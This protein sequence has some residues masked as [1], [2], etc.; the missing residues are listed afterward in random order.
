M[1]YRSDPIWPHH[2]FNYNKVV[3]EH[4]HSHLFT[5]YLRLFSSYETDWVVAKKTV[6]MSLEKDGRSEVE[7]CGLHYGVR[8]WCFGEKS[9]KA[10]GEYGGRKMTGGELWKFRL[11]SLDLIKWAG[12]N[13]CVISSNDS[14]SWPLSRLHEESKE[15]PEAGAQLAPP[16]SHSAGS[17]EENTTWLTKVVMGTKMLKSGRFWRGRYSIWILI[18]QS[19][20]G[21][22]CEKFIAKRGDRPVVF[23]TWTEDLW[24]ENWNC[25][26]KMGCT[27]IWQGFWDGGKLGI[28]Q[29]RTH[30]IYILLFNKLPQNDGIKC[31][32]LFILFMN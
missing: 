2:F 8:I 25:W 27:D 14:E 20:G 28:S 6:H 10:E 7:Q 17:N 1:N 15:R 5:C 3:L 26:E 12:G 13:L 16:V 23:I 32:Q 21:R 19:E 30:F 4:S 9:T 24:G 22:K 29:V 11:I 18:S 31:K